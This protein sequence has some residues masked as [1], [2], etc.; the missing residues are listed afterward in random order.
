[1]YS[2]RA[3]YHNSHAPGVLFKYVAST[4]C[5]FFQFGMPQ[6]H[7]TFSRII[8]AIVGRPLGANRI[9]TTKEL[10]PDTLY[11]WHGCLVESLPHLADHID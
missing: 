7:L 11:P 9:P 1:M 10:D 6:A 5:S 4:W 8:A 2:S 3:V